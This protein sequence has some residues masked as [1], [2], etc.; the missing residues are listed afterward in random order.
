MGS[1]FGTNVSYKD[2][3]VGEM[4]GAFA[5]AFNLSS[6]EAVSDEPSLDVEGLHKGLLSV[7][8]SF[9]MRKQIRAK[10][11]FSLIVK[12]VGR[13]VGFHFLRNRVMSL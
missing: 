3:L 13:T 2:K 6:K 9:D 12:V 5:Q 7:K 10:W 4:P 11:A 8:L 1:T